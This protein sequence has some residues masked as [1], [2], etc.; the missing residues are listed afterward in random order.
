M[1]TRKRALEVIFV[2]ASPG[3]DIPESSPQPSFIQPS[4][5]HLPTPESF[6]SSPPPTPSNI[7]DSISDQPN[8]KQRTRRN[9][10]T[11]E[12][13]AARAEERAERNRKAAKESRDRKK[14]LYNT[15]EQENERLR[16]EN[17]MLRERMQS[18]EERF[19]IMEVSEVKQQ[20]GD[21]EMQIDFGQTHCPAAVMSHD[22]QCHPISISLPSQNTRCSQKSRNPSL[23]ISDA[24]NPTPVKRSTRSTSQTLTPQRSTSRRSLN[25]PNKTSITF[26]PQSLCHTSTG[27]RENLSPRL[28]TSMRLLFDSC[29]TLDGLNASSLDRGAEIISQASFGEVSVADKRF[30]LTGADVEHLVSEFVYKGHGNGIGSETINSNSMEVSTINLKSD[31]IP[32]LHQSCKCAQVAL[33]DRRQS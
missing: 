5:L 14:D 21:G 12:E 8:K 18:L 28:P 29:A 4:M 6:V 30:L 31:V 19:A 9:A 23:S 10:K 26:S 15:L 13:K 25:L 20:Y 24:F 1:Q 22:Q 7:T 2:P 3:L 27:Q 11:E 16:T 33:A 32:M 17:Q